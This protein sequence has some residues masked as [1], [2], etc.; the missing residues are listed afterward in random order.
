MVIAIVIII[1][2]LN[3]PKVADISE[4]ATTQTSPSSV[5]QTNVSSADTSSNNKEVLTSTGDNKTENAR[6]TVT[7]TTNSVF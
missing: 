6:K 2:S 7:K 4:S 3:L 5:L 1:Y